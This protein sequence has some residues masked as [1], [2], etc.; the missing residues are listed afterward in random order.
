VK[1]ISEIG[2]VVD[3]IPANLKQHLLLF[4]AIAFV[5]VD[6][7]IEHLRARNRLAPREDL[8]SV[9]ND[10][11][12]LASKSLVYRTSTDETQIEQFSRMISAEGV[13]PE[14]EIVKKLEAESAQRKT[15]LFDE[16]G[17]L[18]KR[19]R[20][21]NSELKGFSDSFNN[22]MHLQRVQEFLLGRILARKIQFEGIDAIALSDEFDSL[23]GS[24]SDT[25]KASNVIEVVLNRVPLPAESTP[26]EAIL[27][28]RSDPRTKQYL[29]GLRV[30]MAEIAR[31]DLSRKELEQKLDWL[32]FQQSE[33]LR[34]HRIAAGNGAMGSIFVGG[35]EMLE[36]AAKFRLGKIAKALVSLTGRRT[37]LLKSELSAPA[38]ELS[39]L[40]RAEEAFGK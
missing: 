30:W 29:N 33:H 31:S 14:V 18:K 15:I 9:A 11:E 17:R 3:D 22:A 38:K 24:Q 36:D 6:G 39:Y 1:S 4:D 5:D 7:K 35:M 37:E 16:F 12:F 21:T 40:L 20:W 28:F 26:W 8:V 27:E 19:K 23:L 34:V 10:I 13:P 2:V 32:M 25:K